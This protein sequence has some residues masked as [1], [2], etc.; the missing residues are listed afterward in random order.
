MPTALD[1]DRGK[2]EQLREVLESLVTQ[3]GP[4]AVLPSERQ[5]TELYGVARMTVRAQIRALAADG[6][7]TIKA[8]SGV[9][10]ADSPH[11]TL[12]VGHSFSHEMRERGLTPGSV[13]L[14][15][16]VLLVNQRLSELL[17]AQVGSRALRLVR[18]R[19]ADEVPVGI[20][21][22][23]VSL[24]RFPDID[25]IDFQT[26]S[27]YDTLRRDYGVEPHSVEARATAVLPSEDEAELLGIAVTEPCL[28]VKS[29]HTD[30]DGVVIEAGR[31]IYRGDRYD[32]DVA[33]RP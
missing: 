24:E 27:L 13:L 12:A 31:S 17:G 5:L 21:R 15:H 1:A 28:A 11:P 2:G 3:L 10:V 9:Y 8:G 7:L 33:R 25:K 18:L 4:G 6:V 16:N 19:T 32:V 26:A 30:A 14:E 22:T 23:T 20:E 29:L